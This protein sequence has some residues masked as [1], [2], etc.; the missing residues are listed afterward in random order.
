MPSKSWVQRFL[1]MSG[2]SYKK[3]GVDVM[4]EYGHGVSV[5]DMAIL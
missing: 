5:V 3:P 4:K 2:H 1:G